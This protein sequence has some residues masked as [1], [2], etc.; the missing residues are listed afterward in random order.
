[1]V[2]CSEPVI[3]APLSGL[4]APIF[5]AQRHQARHLGFGDIDLLAAEIG[6]GNVLDDIV[7]GQGFG[8][9]G[10]VNISDVFSL[11]RP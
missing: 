9:R 2:M 7:A 5:A 4:D 11:R 6:E 3:R 10:H 1:M 8:G